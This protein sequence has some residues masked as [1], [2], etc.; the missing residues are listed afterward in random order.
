M[1][2]VTPKSQGS[3]STVVFIVITRISCHDFLNI[4]TSAA[5]SSVFNGTYTHYF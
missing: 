5:V 2:H 4:A 1:E 3:V